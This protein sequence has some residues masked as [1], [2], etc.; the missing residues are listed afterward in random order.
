MGILVGEEKEGHIEIGGQIRN[1]VFRGK[2]E[3][4]VSV[5]SRAWT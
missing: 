3:W 5:Q 1:G 2:L 4:G